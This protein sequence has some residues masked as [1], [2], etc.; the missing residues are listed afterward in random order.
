M[1]A[2]HSNQMGTLNA[3]L[4]RLALRALAGHYEDINQSFFKG[5]LRRPVLRLS[6]SDKTLGQWIS[7]ERILELSRSLLCSC[8]WGT[9]LETLKHEMAHQAADELLGAGDDPGETAHGYAIRH[10]CELLGLH[11]RA[12]LGPGLASGQE[13]PVVARIRKL[14]ALAESANVHEAQ[15]AMAKARQLMDRFEGDLDV[16][17]AHFYHQYLGKPRRRRAMTAQLLAGLL[18]RFFHVEVVWIPS[19]LLL[20][21][22]KVW[23]LEACGSQTHLDVAAYVHDYLERELETRWLAMRRRNPALKGKMA[24]RDFQ[25]GLLK[26]LAEK[27]ASTDD[28]VKPQAAAAAEGRNTLMD[29]RRGHL[30]AFF[31]A[32]HPHLR[33]GR[34]SRHRLTDSF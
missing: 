5:L 10:A 25:V 17:D 15:S 29:I 27:L 3:E 9:V 7:G 28:A 26:G 21:E 6:S 14:L 18:T 11:H 8:G 31:Q 22:Q 33:A 34:T 23:L 1:V 32:R 2:A 13:P 20:K 4:E 24:K 19:V 12:R 30:R 16:A